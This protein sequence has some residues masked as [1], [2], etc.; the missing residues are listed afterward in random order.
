MNGRS[1]APGPGGAPRWFYHALAGCAVVAT[2]LYVHRTVSV[3]LAERRVASAV[4]AIIAPAAAPS[5]AP[6]GP[7]RWV[8]IMEPSGSGRPSDAA[9]DYIDAAN[10]RWSGDT[11]SVAMQT[12]WP[13]VV[14]G[15]A[16]KH[17]RSP[18]Q[19]AC[20]SPTRAYRH[21]FGEDGEWS[22]WIA[23]PSGAPGKRRSD[24]LIDTLCSL[25]KAGGS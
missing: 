3:Q 24:S 13:G 1:N 14:P 5:A 19:A 12:I 22:A 17:N 4:N 18:L 10:H 7:S 20:G 6:A 21:R 9:A 15:Q 11:V 8:R 2:V 16:D 25:G 23:E